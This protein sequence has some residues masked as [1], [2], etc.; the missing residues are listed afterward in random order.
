MQPN[1]GQRHRRNLPLDPSISS[2]EDNL[3]NRCKY[4]LD[5]DDE[6]ICKGK[7][8]FLEIG[9][10]GGM[11]KEDLIWGKSSI[12]SVYLFSYELGLPKGCIYTTSNWLFQLGHGLL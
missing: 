9:S 8:G 2:H 10:A 7:Q 12:M 5:K 3:S 11:G 1:P 6:H 4:M